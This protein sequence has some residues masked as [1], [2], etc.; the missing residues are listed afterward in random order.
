MASGACWG[1]ISLKLNHIPTSSPAPSAKPSF[2]F[3]SILLLLWLLLMLLMMML[4]MSSLCFS[5]LLS[6]FPH[7]HRRAGMEGD[8]R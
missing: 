5:F 7:S 4:P 3:L 6:L 8:G 1:K 2:F